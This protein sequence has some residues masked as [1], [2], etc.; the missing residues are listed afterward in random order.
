MSDSCAKSAE[1]GRGMAEDK[2][3]AEVTAVVPISGSDVNVTLRARATKP[4]E[5]E[6][7]YFTTVVAYLS[8]DRKRPIP[9]QPL[10]VHRNGGDAG[11]AS[12]KT[13]SPQG[14]FSC[15]IELPTVG[16]HI[17]AIG[18]PETDLWVGLTVTAPKPPAEKSREEKK[19]GELRH[20]IELA[21]K[22]GELIE[23]EEAL[24]KKR[25]KQDPGLEIKLISSLREGDN[26]MVSLRRQK[27][28]GSVSTGSIYFFDWHQEDA[29]VPPAMTRFA[30]EMTESDDFADVVR[31]LLADPRKIEFFLPEDVAKK[32]VVEVPAKE[33]VVPT[34]T[35]PRPAAPTVS[36]FDRGKAAAHR[37]FGAASVADA[38][39]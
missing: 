1:R 23:A 16:E 4:F 25:K 36:S 28:D 19:I 27:S 20:K 24:K 10:F 26:V 11:I 2:L 31:P 15:D 13:R 6:G 14:Q 34:R 35:E 30:V 17:I 3:A 39:S 37:L 9:N 5:R 33:V 21:G 18:I 38:R 8:R 12:P 22:S 7:K 29:A 32:V